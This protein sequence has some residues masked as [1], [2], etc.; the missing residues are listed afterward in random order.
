MLM[1]HSCSV[2]GAGAGPPS[3]WLHWLQG[4]GLPFRA[5]QSKEPGRPTS[6]GSR[7]AELQSS[8]P[9]VGQWNCWVANLLLCLSWG[10]CEICQVL[11][12]C[13]CVLMCQTLPI[14]LL[15]HPE[16]QDRP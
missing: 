10:H 4:L 16:P 1:N 6:W 3:A 13:T 9:A 12:P 2:D 11:A 5:Q 14:A 8:C 7:Q 15:P